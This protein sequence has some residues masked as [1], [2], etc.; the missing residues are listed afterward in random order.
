M[1]ERIADVMMP[2]MDS[3]ELLRQ[4]RLRAQTSVLMV[5]GAGSPQGE[6][7]SSEG[8]TDDYI[9]KPFSGE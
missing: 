6:I 3:Y 1:E 7:F 9:H 2:D 8:G 5:T 4:I